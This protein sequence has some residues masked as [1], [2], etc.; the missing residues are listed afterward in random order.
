[1]LAFVKS[2]ILKCRY[3]FPAQDPPVTM[4]EPCS[5]KCPNADA[6]ILAQHA[7]TDPGDEE[8]QATLWS[9]ARWFY[10]EPD[11]LIAAQVRYAAQLYTRSDSDG[12][13]IPK[14]ILFAHYKNLQFNS[15][16]PPLKLSNH[17]RAAIRGELVPSWPDGEP[18][19]GTTWNQ[20]FEGYSLGYDQPLE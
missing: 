1:M 14:T 11:D 8:L 2:R 12:T 16:G 6:A 9:F 5:A 15:D 18:A 17:A 10:D 20:M 4:P 3:P 13:C 19:S 7:S